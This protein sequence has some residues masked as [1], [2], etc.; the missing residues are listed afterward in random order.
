[1]NEGQQARYKSDALP[2]RIEFPP[3]TFQ[4]GLIFSTVPIL[5]AAFIAL[6]LDLVPHPA[7]ETNYPLAWILG[8]LFL[9]IGFYL[10]K[11]A[12]T[13]PKLVLA[14]EGLTWGD[15]LY[16]WDTIQGFGVIF[17]YHGFRFYLYLTP[18][19]ST[20]ELTP[21][22]MRLGYL[23]KPTMEV[24]TAIQDYYEQIRGEVLPNL[25]LPSR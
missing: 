4:Y 19:P 10:M 12:L 7:F 6:A 2:D 5:G 3:A 14:P 9:G 23:V 11:W 1:M 13:R 15:Q 22:Q 17:I 8:V 18:N 16:P 24:V 21:I 20:H 25:G